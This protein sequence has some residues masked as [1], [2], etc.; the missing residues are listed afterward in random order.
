MSKCPGVVI[1]RTE[2][3][4]KAGRCAY[5]SHFTGADSPLPRLTLV[6]TVIETTTTTTYM[7]VVT[8]V[9]LRQ[10]NRKSSV[11]DLRESL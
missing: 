9:Y 1:S 10:V 5:T 7:Y 11:R 2:A 8:G 6:A 4:R 3:A